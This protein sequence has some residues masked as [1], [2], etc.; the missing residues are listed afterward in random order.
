[1]MTLAERIKLKKKMIQQRTAVRKRAGTPLVQKSTL[2]KKTIEKQIAKDK[3]EL[4][5]LLKKQSDEKVKKMKTVQAN[6]RKVQSD[7]KDAKK[8]EDAKKPGFLK[9]LQKEYPY[10]IPPKG[11]DDLGKGQ[12]IT[13]GR[14]RTKSNTV[15]DSDYG[16]K[17]KKKKKK[18]ESFKPSANLSDAFKAN[19]ENGFNPL[20]P[21]SMAKNKSE[22][23]PKSKNKKDPNY[24]LYDNV[25]GKKLGMAGMT[26]AGY[27]AEENKISEYKSGGKIKKL[28]YGGKVMKKAKGGFMGKGAGC[29]RTGY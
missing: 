27:E 18:E 11:T 12:A 17:I 19:T 3:K 6:T 15:D 29:A 16:T 28:K 24:K 20:S 21:E 13:I 26:D 7:K 5:L 22:K 25:L 9:R 2:P 8:V 14:S 23:S 10:K 1:M 4:N